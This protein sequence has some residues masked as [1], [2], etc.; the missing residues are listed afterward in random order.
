MSDLQKRIGDHDKGSHPLKTD[1]EKN[2]YFG[3]W[4]GVDGWVGEGG[5]LKM[6]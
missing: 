5:V 6:S 3:G 4:F 2:A 1:I